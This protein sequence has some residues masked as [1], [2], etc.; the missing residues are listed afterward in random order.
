MFAP[1][2]T[3]IVGAQQYSHYYS[4]IIRQNS[5]FAHLFTVRGVIGFQIDDP[6]SH[7]ACGRN[8]KIFFSPA[9]E[10]S[11]S[12]GNAINAVSYLCVYSMVQ[13][14]GTLRFVHH[15]FVKY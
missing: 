7:S 3:S 15:S 14:T 2:A 5:A 9:H 13:A 11:P 1:V 8:F 6:P 4:S 10:P 12:T